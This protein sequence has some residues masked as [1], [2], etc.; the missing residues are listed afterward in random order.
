MVPRPARRVHKK[1]L[2]Y[3]NNG[4][5]VEQPLGRRLDS[6]YAAEHNDV[7]SGGAQNGIEPRRQQKV[8]GQPKQRRVDE[9]QIGRV[10][11]R[12]IPIGQQTAMCEQVGTGDKLI[13]IVIKTSGEALGQKQE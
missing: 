10:K 4:G 11:I 6:P 7:G 12:I 13:L 9:D 8:R 5:A 2:V 3:E 1:G